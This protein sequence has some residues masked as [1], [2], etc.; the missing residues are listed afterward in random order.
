M[1]K[2]F[3]LWIIKKENISSL[4]EMMSTKEGLVKRS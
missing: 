4:V 3:K 1:G 2:S